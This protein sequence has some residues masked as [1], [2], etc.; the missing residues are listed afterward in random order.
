MPAF[1][2]RRGRRGL[3]AVAHQFLHAL[4]IGL[5]LFSV[6]LVA[7]PVAERYSPAHE[8]AL[9]VAVP[10]VLVFE[11][12]SGFVHRFV[13]WL[14]YGS[15]GDAATASLQ[16]A[17]GL[18]QLDD[19]KAVTGLAAALVDT[20]RLS[21]LQV[22]TELDGT[23][24]MLVEHGIPGVESTRFPIT[25]AG[26]DLGY[27]SARRRHTPLD[28]RDERLLHAAAAQLGVVLHVNR[29]AAQLQRARQDLVLSREDERKRLRLELHDG[30]GPTLAGIGLGLEAAGNALP[31][32]ISRAQGLLSDVR[33]DVAGL[34]ED[35]RRVVDGLR[36]P[37]LDEVGLVGALNQQATT[38]AAR[39]GWTVHLESGPLPALPAAIEVAAYRIGSE[40]LTN[41]ARHA[42]ATRC[43]IRISCSAGAFLMEI[44]DDGLGGA[45][46]GKG[47]GL[48]S[49]RERAMELGGSVAFDS[50]EQG[51][52]V[53]V[54][55]PLVGVS[56]HD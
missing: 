56:R 6:A 42:R 38:F 9:V 44:N 4:I 43:D 35:V 54:W 55:L 12:A 29:L 19:D 32:D 3:D 51:T 41:V 8:G 47:T 34:I 52:T 31:T 49:I 18:E 11:L 53:R 28:V 46:A 27:L 1:K 2:S 16:L 36:P 25:H 40:A 33:T 48:A 22:V 21:H 20:L 17:K 13:D 10:L 15:R 23:R 30:V 50:G 45:S 7:V 24:T 26:V 39:V 5:V 14:L 37:L